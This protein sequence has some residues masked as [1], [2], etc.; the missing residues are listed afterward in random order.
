[1]KSLRRKEI[2]VIGDRILKYIRM[3]EV[4]VRIVIC[5]GHANVSNGFEQGCCDRYAFDCEKKI[6]VQFSATFDD[7]GSIFLGAVDELRLLEQFSKGA[8]RSAANEFP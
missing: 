8:P 3:A 7:R 4:Y 2:V 1:M 6:W 5:G